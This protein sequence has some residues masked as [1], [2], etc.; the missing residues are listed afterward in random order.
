MRFGRAISEKQM[1]KALEKRLQWLMNEADEDE[2]D[3]K[4][5]TAIVDLLEA[6]DPLE[7][8]EG[9]FFTPQKANDRFWTFYAF[10]DRNDDE[11]P[12]YDN[13]ATRAKIKLKRFIYGNAFARLSFVTML[14]VAI[15]FGGTLVVFAQKEGFFHWVREDENVAAAITTPNREIDSTEQLYYKSLDDVP[16]KYL[17]YVWIPNVLP[18]DFKLTD[19]RIYNDSKA[20]VVECLLKLD[21]TKFIKFRKKDF[22]SI[23]TVTSQTYD[24]FEHIDMQN[25]C[26]V[27]VTYLKKTN[28]DYTEYMVSFC[29]E[30]AIYFVHSNKDIED[31]SPIV[32]SC[33]EE[34]LK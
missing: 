33:I 27:D 12:P 31:I 10:R 18:T 7:K 5:A 11:K 23:S 29:I 16:I 9:E 21:E 20:V 24:S 28:D 25:V 2:F 26:G 17:K 22:G 13:F 4:E 1:I 6:M 32:N 15:V 19:I 30:N 34:L 3:S 14:L 8:R